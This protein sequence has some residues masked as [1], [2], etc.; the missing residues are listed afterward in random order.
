MKMGPLLNKTSGT[1][2]SGS[3]S[4][5]F[6]TYWSPDFHTL[7]LLKTPFNPVAAAF[8]EKLFGFG[9]CSINFNC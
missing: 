5:R 9:W 3:G 4:T 2:W 1:A 6:I 8:K 7:D